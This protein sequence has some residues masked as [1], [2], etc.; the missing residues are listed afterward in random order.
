MSR[1]IQRKKLYKTGVYQV[2]HGRQVSY[3]AF[4]II[5]T[6]L[7]LVVDHNA[8]LTTTLNEKV[9]STTM[10]LSLNGVPLGMEDEIKRN[11]EGY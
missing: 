9:D 2:L 7:S 10:T 11:L 4:I 1:W 8:T 6:L 3:G 5:K